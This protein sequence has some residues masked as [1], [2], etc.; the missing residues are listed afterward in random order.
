MLPCIFREIKHSTAALAPNGLILY[1]ESN[2]ITNRCR[3]GLKAKK[4][5]YT[6]VF[7]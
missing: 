2:P 1:G 3:M 4:L 5:S 6:F 7:M